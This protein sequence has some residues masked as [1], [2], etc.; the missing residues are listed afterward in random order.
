MCLI[1]GVDIPD[2]PYLTNLMA[3]VSD[4]LGLLAYPD[5][6][7]WAEIKELWRMVEENDGRP[8]SEMVT[9]PHAMW[10]DRNM[11]LSVLHGIIA[12]AKWKLRTEVE[13][14]VGY[15]QDCA[16]RRLEAVSWH[17]RVYDL[18]D[19]LSR[20]T[21]PLWQKRIKLSELKDLLGDQ[22]YFNGCIPEPLP[23]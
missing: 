14:N 10:G 23:R 20:D 4:E 11:Y 18:L 8:L 17:Y 5:A 7:S 6:K 3:Q 9:F 16:R 15:A 21:V 13:N 1:W 22:M 19:D 12:P 2:H